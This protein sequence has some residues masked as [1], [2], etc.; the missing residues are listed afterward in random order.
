MTKIGRVGLGVLAAVTALGLGACNTFQSRS[1]ER[2]ATYEA[3]DPATQ[4][5]LQSG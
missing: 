4:H 5:R 3:L 1:R 2:A